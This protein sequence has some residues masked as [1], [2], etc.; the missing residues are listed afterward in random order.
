MKGIKLS[1]KLIIGILLAL[2]FGIALYFRVYF[3]YEQVFG[4]A[5]VKNTGIDA[6]YYMRLADNLARA[7]VGPCYCLAEL[8]A[9][10]LYRTVRDEL[11]GQ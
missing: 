9:A 2:F 11:D 5:W 10:D 3:P 1:P 4:S 6:Y 8:K 7:L